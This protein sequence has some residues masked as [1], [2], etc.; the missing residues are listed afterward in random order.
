MQFEGQG[1]AIFIASVDLMIEQIKHK[2]LDEVTMILKNY[3]TMIHQTGKYNNKILGNLVIFNHV[4]AQLNR[5]HCAEII[6]LALKNIIA[7][8]ETSQA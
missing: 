5:L 3:E 4:K 1:C 6:L 7:E 8:H 2:T